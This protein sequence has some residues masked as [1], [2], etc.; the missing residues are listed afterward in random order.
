MLSEDNEVKHYI[1]KFF[2]FTSIVIIM[3]MFFYLLVAWDTLPTTIPAHYNYLGEVDRWGSKNELWVWPILA[4][5]IFCMNH[6][7][8]SRPQFW[9]LGGIDVNLI[10]NKQSLFSDMEMFLNVLNWG[11]VFMFSY[12]FVS[13]I[14]QQNLNKWFLCI[15][16]FLFGVL[17]VL[18]S[19][20]VYKKYKYVNK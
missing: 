1:Y 7:F 20:Y 18:F 12:F 15:F 6:F 19:L 4:L 16:I 3:G 13:I 10:H 5:L 9:N 8:K 2:N 11:I 17:P 14:T